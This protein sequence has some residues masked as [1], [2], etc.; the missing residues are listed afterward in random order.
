MKEKGKRTEGKTLKGGQEK[1]KSW[2]EICKV[3]FV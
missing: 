2:K 1:G 3:L